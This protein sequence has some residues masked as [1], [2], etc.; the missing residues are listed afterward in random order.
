[1]CG[2]GVASLNTFWEADVFVADVFCW[3]GDAE[4]GD[5]D[6]LFGWDYRGR[7]MTLSWRGEEVRH[8]LF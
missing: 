3:A 8:S 7:L 6:I 4:R 5:T 1:M 2:R